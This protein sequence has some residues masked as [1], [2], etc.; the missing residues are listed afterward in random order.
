[1]LFGYNNPLATPVTLDAGTVQNEVILSSSSGNTVFTGQPS[2]F[3]PVL[4]DRLFQVPLPTGEVTVT[5]TLDGNTIGP[6]PRETTA[7]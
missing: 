2:T 1:M 6:Y 3:F 7:C 5:W 4:H